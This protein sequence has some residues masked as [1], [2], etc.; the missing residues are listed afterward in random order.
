MTSRPPKWEC[1][2]SVHQRDAALTCDESSATPLSIQSHQQ[3]PLPWGPEIEIVCLWLSEHFSSVHEADSWF[4]GIHVCRYAAIS[5]VR[6]GPCCCE[7]SLW[8]LESFRPFTITGAETIQPLIPHQRLILFV[9]TESV[10]SLQLV[11]CLL[12]FLKVAACGALHM[13]PVWSCRREMHLF[14]GDVKH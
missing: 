2:C 6:T 14:C 1:A 4:G 7:T 13:I 9:C 8:N 10:R 12:F 11:S 3:L 5:G